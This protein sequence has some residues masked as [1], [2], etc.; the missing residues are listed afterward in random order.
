MA[1]LDKLTSRWRSTGG[2][3]DPQ[4]APVVPVRVISDPASRTPDLD[5][6]VP[7]GIRLASGWAWRLMIVA[8]FIY[9]VYWLLG[10]LSEVSVPLVV[11][12][13]L[14][15]ALWPLKEWHVERNVPRGLAVVISLLV[16]LG[17]VL[18][19]IALVS[20]QIA[21]QWSS[22][23][24]EAI[25]SFEQLMNWL[26]NGPF[27][28]SNSQID[29]WL[30]KATDYVKNSS[31]TIASYAGKVGTGVG[32]FFA[33][34]ALALFATFYF[35]YEGKDLARSASLILPRR[36]RGRIM[37]A[38]QRGW[39]A[40]VSYV[41]AAIIV[42]AVD[43]LG[44]LIGAAAIGSNMWLAIGALTFLCAFVPLLGALFS[45][46]VAVGVVFVTLGWAR[47]V[48]MLVVFVAV[49]EIEAHVLQPFLL[50][51]AVSIHP[52]VV[53]FGLAAGMIIGGIIGGLFTVPLLAF[54]NAFLRA[55]SP[56]TP[57]SE[58]P[59]KEDEFPPDDDAEPARVSGATAVG[60]ASE[61]GSGALSPGA[62]PGETSVPENPDQTLDTAQSES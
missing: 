18:G 48:I 58:V 21:T 56:E 59:P 19:I 37:D 10:Y 61:T 44:A 57:P 30:Q 24:S 55:W 36:S 41:R 32:H 45:G 60:A 16:L 8:A 47:A 34:M 29:T 51:H 33:G 38:A 14:T 25:K 40:L 26:A 1:R 46:A 53:L 17:I 42:A 54:G 43:G 62:D 52:L 50:G 20:A 27:H 2:G 49:M 22:L 6:Q 11:A 15:A 9:G 12:M 3:H 23:T 7:D 31:S 4:P 28:V 39:V 35:L 13:L 5:A